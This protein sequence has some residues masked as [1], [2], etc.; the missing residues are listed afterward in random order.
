MEEQESDIFGDDC[1]DDC[2]D[3]LS[4]Y[5]TTTHGINNQNIP[6]DEEKIVLHDCQEAESS[7]MNDVEE[8][9]RSGDQ[10]SENCHHHSGESTDHIS[11]LLRRQSPIDDALFQCDLNLSD[12]EEKALLDLLDFEGNPS[13]SNIFAS[14]LLMYSSSSNGSIKNPDRYDVDD[15]L[16]E[17]VAMANAVVSKGSPLSSTSKMVDSCRDNSNGER[18]VACVQET[19]RESTRMQVAASAGKILLT[20]TF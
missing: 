4:K 11:S 12:P 10:S 17:L 9:M 6:D 13:S 18:D 19:T 5:T 3:D 14:D 15:R 20:F 16:S 1:I 2:E 7:M 8:C